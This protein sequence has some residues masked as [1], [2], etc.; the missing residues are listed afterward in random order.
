MTMKVLLALAGYLI[1]SIPFGLMISRIWNLDIRQYGSSNIGATNVYRILGTLAGGFVLILDYLKGF[2]AV[3]LGYFLGGDPMVILLLALTVV[4]GHMF[5]VFLAFRGG[6]GVA[7][8]LGVL[9]A[10]RPD[11]FLYTLLFGLIILALTRLVSLASI[12][13][14]LFAVILFFL[15][16]VPQIYTITTVLLAAAIILAH[17]PNIRRLIAGREPRLGESI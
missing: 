5:S 14:C 13:A 12:S 1:G 9:A 15:L 4:L 8:G 3:S 17:L 6:K 11:I 7:T 16:H 2:I 10:I